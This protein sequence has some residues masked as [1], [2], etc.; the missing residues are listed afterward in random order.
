MSVL[1]SIQIPVPFS[2]KM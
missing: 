2:H 1:G